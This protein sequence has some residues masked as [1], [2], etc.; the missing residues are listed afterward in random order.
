MEKEKI[1]FWPW[2]RN[3]LTVSF[4]VALGIVG[5]TILVGVI[6]LIVNI[7]D[8]HYGKYA[9]DYDR[10]LSENVCVHIFGNGK[11]R[12][13]DLS[14]GSY[15]TPRLDWVSVRPDRDS[16]AV[17]SKDGLRGFINVHTGK[18]VIE[19][20]YEHAW[21]FSE[22]LAAVVMP[23]KKMGFIDKSGKYVIDPHFDYMPTHDYVFKHGVC[24]IEGKNGLYKLLCK[25]G[26]WALSDEYDYIGIVVKC[27]QF[28]PSRH[29][30]LR[31]AS[32]S[33]HFL[34]FLY[35]VPVILAGFFR[36]MSHQGIVLPWKFCSLISIPPYA[37]SSFFFL[38]ILSAN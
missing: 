13:Y 3:V 18:I 35:H 4:K 20:K 37:A 24:C 33:P 36:F 7:Y 17:F 29:R 11:A 27:F 25:D 5:L 30:A 14:S 21:V 32:A 6:S 19:N 16:L 9:H 15:T 31:H 28:G 34:H 8:E 12:A 38:A 23:G 2:I 10:K 26:A 1:N 22:G